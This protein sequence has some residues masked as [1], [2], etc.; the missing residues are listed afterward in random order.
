MDIKLRKLART[1]THG[2]CLESTEGRRRAG[3]A[4]EHKQTMEEADV[5]ESESKRPC[6][7]SAGNSHPSAFYLGCTLWRLGAPCVPGKKD[8][9]FEGRVGRGP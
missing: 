8:A 4:E 1:K 9:V 2:E 7:C 3:V 6:E 5:F